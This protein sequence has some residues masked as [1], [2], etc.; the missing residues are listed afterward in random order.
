MNL[1]QISPAQ[2]RATDPLVASS[3]VRRA[4]SSLWAI[5][6]ALGAHTLVPAQG[7]W[8]AGARVYAKNCANVY[9]HGDRGSAGAAPAVAGKA[10]SFEQVNRIVRDGIPDTAMAGWK[11]T[12]SAADLASV[13]EYVFALQKSKAAKRAELDANRPWLDHPGRRLFF[14]PNRI[15]PCGSCHD[16]DGLGLAVA[17]PF[18][19]PPPA[20]PTR[21]RELTSDRV[22]IVRPAGAEPFIA[23]PATSR[24]GVPRWHELAEELPVLRT[25]RQAPLDAGPANSWSH[26]G[27][28]RTY[29]DAE[30]EEVIEFLREAAAE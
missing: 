29:T 4:A 24:A 8:S 15:T 28:I 25:F 3:R 30:L 7:I 5:L 18:E 9:C 27:V 17:L 16:F 21:L 10:L 14:D 22:R 13:I 2:T 12:L 19:A 20:S 6:L 26:A 11:N 1:T 23:V